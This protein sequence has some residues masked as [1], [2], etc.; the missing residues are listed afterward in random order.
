MSNYDA[1]FLE[2]EEY[3]A[4]D[5]VVA[6]SPHGSVFVE[7]RWLA[8][9]AEAASTDVGIAGVFDGPRL[10][11]GVPVRRSTRL[12]LRTALVPPMCPVNSC[13]VSPA[14]SAAG[15]RQERRLLDV[16][17]RLALFLQ[18]R[19][20][21]AVVVNDPAMADVR[22]FGWEDWRS[23][24]LYTYRLD[25]AAATLERVR[26]AGERAE[27]RRGACGVTIED[28]A[29]PAAFHALLCRDVA[30]QGAEPPVALEPF[31]RLC[32]LRPDCVQVRLARLG[33]P[34][35]HVAGLVYVNDR[36][37][38]TTYAMWGAF[39]P[40]RVQASVLPR[41]AWSE[42][43]AL[44]DAGVRTLD[45]VG[46]NVEDSM[47]YKSQFGARLVPYYQVLHASVWHRLLS[48]IPTP[49]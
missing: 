20:S 25:L 35:D 34:E 17:R 23:S 3:P 6:E 2:P 42:L 15:P 37:R 9:V 16:T 39:D 36:P 4:W 45:L 33:T 29:D 7:S 32:A 41:L 5:E 8:A 27:R 18:D 43:Q 13:V 1:R 24:V 21:Y 44:R 30:R 40:D 31:A 48:R 38:R 49:R 11:A 28:Q 26:A 10:L 46:A 22:G 14:A 19:F 47:R 12:G